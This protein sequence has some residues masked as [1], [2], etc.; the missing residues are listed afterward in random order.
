MGIQLTGFKPPPLPRWRRITSIV[1]AALSV[2]ALA[3]AVL[4]VWNPASLVVLHQHAG[5]PVRDLFFTMVLVAVAAWLG[6]PV[7][8]EAAQHRRLVVRAWTIALTALLGLASLTTLGLSA[9]RYQPQVIASSADGQRSVALVTLL[10]GREL[11]AF[12]GS[13]LGARDE[14]SL[15][16]P[17]GIRV[18]AQF[19]G[20]DQ[21]RVITDFGTFDLRLDPATGRPATHLGPTCSG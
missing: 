11:H 8:S 5:D 19:T 21:V 9:F 17:C 3:V 7:L 13:G 4:G 6:L 14:G 1:A 18:S 12:V 16:T 20:R 2:L 15:G 10:H